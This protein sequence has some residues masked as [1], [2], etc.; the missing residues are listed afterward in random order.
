MTWWHDDM[1]TWWH[2]DMMPG[3]QVIRSSGHQVIRSS[4]HHVI[5]SSGH[6][7]I[8]SSCHRHQAMSWCSYAD[9]LTTRNSLIYWGGFPFIKKSSDFQEENHFLRKLVRFI[10]GKCI[11]CKGRKIV[12]LGR[13]KKRSKTVMIFD[14]FKERSWKFMKKRVFFN[15]WSIFK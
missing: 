4:C 14:R 11:P 12:I 2:D 10:E 9:V 5:M 1:M 8:R 7:V 15:F 13:S 6:H 3:H